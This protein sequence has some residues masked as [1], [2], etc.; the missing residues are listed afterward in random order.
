MAEQG[1]FSF[2]IQAYSKRLPLRYIGFGG[3]GYQVRDV[4]HPDDLATLLWSQMHFTAQPPSRIVSAGGGSKNAMSL[5][6]LSAWCAQRFGEHFISA[7]PSPRPFD[8]PWVIMDI[9]E[10]ESLFGWKI[11]MQL[12]DIL[13]QIEMHTRENPTWF[14]KTGEP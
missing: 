11:T 13:N 12:A 4:F 5:A 6:Q 2:W 7:D 8:I 14:E 3:K 1:I 9:S 10:T